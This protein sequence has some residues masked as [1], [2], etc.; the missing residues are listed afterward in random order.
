MIFSLLCDLYCI[1]LQSVSYQCMDHAIA[2]A[3]MHCIVTVRISVQSQGDAYE[4]CDKKG[5]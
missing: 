3:V 1:A 2:Q 5:G 4:I